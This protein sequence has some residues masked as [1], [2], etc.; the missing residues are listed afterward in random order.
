MCDRNDPAQRLAFGGAHVL[1][2]KAKLRFDFFV[3]LP[4]TERKQRDLALS[5]RQVLCEPPD[6]GVALGL[7]PW[8]LCL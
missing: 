5:W 7:D 8:A 2:Q 1:I 6:R 4:L 3:A